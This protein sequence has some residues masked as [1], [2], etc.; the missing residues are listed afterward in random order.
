MDYIES[1]TWNLP[2]KPLTAPPSRLGALPECSHVPCKCSSIGVSTF[3]YNFVLIYLFV[4]DL[5]QISW[6]GPGLNPLC[7]STA[8]SWAY[9]IVGA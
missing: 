1:L 2:A 7:L 6:Q 9:F 3:Y 5:S 8:Y 4:D